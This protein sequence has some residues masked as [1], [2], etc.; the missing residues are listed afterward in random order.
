MC[1]PAAAGIATNC[2]RLAREVIQSDFACLRAGCSGALADNRAK[3]AGS[4]AFF[5]YSFRIGFRARIFAQNRDR[6]IEEKQS[7]S[8]GPACVASEGG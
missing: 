5:A 1:G 4:A 3:A 7:G 2:I 6:K 8:S